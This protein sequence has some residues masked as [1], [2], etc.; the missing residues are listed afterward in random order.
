MAFEETDLPDGCQ[1][2][3]SEVPMETDTGSFTF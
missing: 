2:V 3:D 1:L